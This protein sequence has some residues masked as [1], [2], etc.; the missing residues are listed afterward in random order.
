MTA[1]HP[2]RA[3]IDAIDAKLSLFRDHPMLIVWGAKD[4]VFT[5]KGFLSGWHNRFPTAEIH[6]LRDAGH[7]VVEDAHERIL[8]L[9]TEFLGRTE[10]S[11]VSFQQSAISGQR[12]ANSSTE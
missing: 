8:P 6:I 4:F 10:L 2:T 3:T 11:A 1:D 7:Y 5:V 12:S 9:V